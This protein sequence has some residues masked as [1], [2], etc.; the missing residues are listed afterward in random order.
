[1]LQVP[2]LSTQGLKQGLDITGQSAFPCLDYTWGSKRPRLDY[3]QVYYGL[4][5]SIPLQPQYTLVTPAC[6]THSQSPD[7]FTDRDFC[8]ILTRL[9]NLCEYLSHRI[10]DC[11]LFITKGPNTYHVLFANQY[12]NQCTVKM[13]SQIMIT[14]F[15]T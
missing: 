13:K 4:G 8:P 15:R 9:R 5:K 12:F 2:L 14:L 6:L 1:M 3:T 11:D 7:H 10:L